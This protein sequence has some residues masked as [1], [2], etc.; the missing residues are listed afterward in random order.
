MPA[1]P[2]RETPLA[3][4]LRKDLSRSLRAGHP[5]VYRDALE[6]PLPA[7]LPTGA[8]VDLRDA[9]GAFLARGLY[10]DASPIAVRVYSRD[11]A[12]AV[13]DALLRRRLA[14]ALALRRAALDLA[15]TDAFRLCHGEG[16]LLPG[17]VLD[18][19]ARA[20]VLSFD[21]AAARTLL[22]LLLPEV[23]AIGRELCVRTIYERARERPAAL[24]EGAPI[25]GEVPVREH[26]VRFLCD[27]VHGQKTGMFL[28]QRENRLL[29]RRYA[30][31]RSVWNGFAYTGGFSVQA[32]LGGA[33][34]VVSVDLAAAALATAR[35]NFAEN[36]LD[37]ERHGFFAADVFSHLRQAIAARERHGLV[38]LD[39][40]SFAPSEKARAKA[41]GAYQDLFALGMQAIAAGGLLAAASC[42]SH[43]DREAFLACLSEAGARVRRPL[44]ILELRGQP[45]DH[46]SPPAFPE[47]RY[48]KFAL[49]AL[50]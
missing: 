36:G 40:P 7:G 24:L 42:S 6:P 3:L 48:L 18:V 11:P 19:Y 17:V 33:A 8:V 26:G 25:A 5:W 39:P 38:I 43:V 13:D 4:S 16:D 35:R 49:L 47:G 37:P 45:A 30:K 9:R 34:R 15:D 1:H 27:V 20:A 10:D 12:E 2:R 46:P 44:R 23:V 29:V 14:A 41:L 32:A 50:D 22:P 28:D 21:G 31:D